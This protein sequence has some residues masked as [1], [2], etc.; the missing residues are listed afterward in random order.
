MSVQYK[1]A[2]KVIIN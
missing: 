2:L 1:I